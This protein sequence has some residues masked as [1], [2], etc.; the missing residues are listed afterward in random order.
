MREIKFRAWDK[1]E[2]RWTDIEHLWVNCDGTIETIIDNNENHYNILKENYIVLMQ[3]IGLKDKNGKE[4]CEGDILVVCNLHD[5]DDDVWIQPTGPAIP[6]VIEWDES[7]KGFYLPAR[8]RYAP[9]D[10]E[11]IG[12]IYD[13]P[14]LLSK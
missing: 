4:I 3:Y 9:Y 12:N 13:N 8:V 1:I 11:V 7:E 5:G 2:K 6:F 10:Y 14:E